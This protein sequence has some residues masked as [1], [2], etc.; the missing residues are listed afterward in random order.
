MEEKT[1]AEGNIMP[2]TNEDGTVCACESCQCPV[3]PEQGYCCAECGDGTEAESCTCG[4]PTCV[5]VA[6]VTRSLRLAYMQS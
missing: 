3:E 2:R 6:W 1:M 5:Q 4:H